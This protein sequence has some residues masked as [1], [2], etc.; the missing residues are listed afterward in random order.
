[1]PV[2]LMWTYF[3]LHT[4]VLFLSPHFGLIS[5]STPTCVDGSDVLSPGG[6]SLAL[7]RAQGSSLIPAGLIKFLSRNLLLSAA[8]S[9]CRDSAPKHR[10]VSRVF[11]MMPYLV[12]FL[13]Q[14]VGMSPT[15][16]ELSLP[17]WNA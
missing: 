1:M 16:P 12:L 14:G 8:T 17:G 7:P 3:C 15:L 2:L 11:G 5:V 9:V 4:L 10:T 13:V 6:R